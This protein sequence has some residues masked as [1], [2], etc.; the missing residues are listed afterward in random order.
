MASPATKHPPAVLIALA[1]TVKKKA[2]DDDSRLADMGQ[3]VLDALE[4]KDA[5][6]VGRIL[7]DLARAAREDKRG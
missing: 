6:E 7:R 2:G 4:K 3:E 1:K 5:K